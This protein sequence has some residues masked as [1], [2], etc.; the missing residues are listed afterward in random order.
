MP[1]IATVALLNGTNIDIIDPR[2][3]CTSC[4]NSHIMN[5]MYLY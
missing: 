1:S 5:T 2:E 3:A 4:R